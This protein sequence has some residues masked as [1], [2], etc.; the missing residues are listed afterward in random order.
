MIQAQNFDADPM[1]PL[2]G[3]VLAVFGPKNSQNDFPDF[4]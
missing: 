1:G 2:P 4:G 3:P